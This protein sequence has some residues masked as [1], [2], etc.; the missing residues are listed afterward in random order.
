M[1]VHAATIRLHLPL[2][3]THSDSRFKSIQAAQ[4]IAFLTMTMTAEAS[5][6]IHADPVLG[7]SAGHPPIQYPIDAQASFRSLG[8]VQSTCSC[9]M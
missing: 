3:P 1:L 2:T 9:S 7:V 5:S 6:G 4:A 8:F